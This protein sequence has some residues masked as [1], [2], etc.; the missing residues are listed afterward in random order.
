MTG[1]YY[2]TTKE[3]VPPE[4]PTRDILSRNLGPCYYAGVIQALLFNKDRG[5]HKSGKPGPTGDEILYRASKV[6][7]CLQWNLLRVI[8]LAPRILSRLLEF[9]RMCAP[10]QYV[11]YT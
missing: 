4:I 7:G 10:L 11:Q 1:E 8:F 9:W 5:V 3:S 2:E 6:C